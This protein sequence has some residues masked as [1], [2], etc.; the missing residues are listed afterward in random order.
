MNQGYE[1]YIMPIIFSIFSQYI[2]I[3]IY[4][5]ILLLAMKGTTERWSLKWDRAGFK[6]RGVGGGNWGETETL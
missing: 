1:H 6:S 2:Y 3:Y 5:Y 4:I